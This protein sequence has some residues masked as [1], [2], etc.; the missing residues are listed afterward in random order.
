[1]HAVSSGAPGASVASVVLV[2]TL[3]FGALAATLASGTSPQLGLDLQGGA[4][5]VLQPRT[6]VPASVL[7]QAIEIIRNRVDGLGVAE[8]DI[9]RQGSSIIVQLPG[10]R[11]RD[12]A[13]EVVGQT[14]ELFFRPVRE[15][16]P[17]AAT[18]TDAAG[19][20]V[21]EGD[22]VLPQRDRDGRVVAHYRVGP[23][24]VTGRALSGAR[25]VV[26]PT[27]GG[28]GVEFSLTSGGTRDWN[29]M[30]ERIGQ[31]G[32]VAIDL[33]GEIKSAPTLQTTNFPGKGQI[34]GDFTQREAKDLALVLRYGS[35]PVQLEPQTVQTVS[36][37]LGRDS[38]RAGVISGL[39][40]LGMVAL[41][42]VAY[43]RALGLVVWLGLAVSAAIM[44]SLVSVLGA[45]T[46]LALTLAGATGVIVSVGVT[47]DSYVVFF[48]RL[49][50]QV[51]AGRSIR[52]SVARGFSGAYRTILAA[53]LASFLGAV[54][55]YVLTVGS[56]RGFAFFLALSTLLDLFIAFFFTR[57][58][59]L[60]LARSRTFTEARWLGVAR[61]LA[62]APPTASALAPASA[63]QG[64]AS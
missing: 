51:R 1:M 2:L 37:T 34:T 11:N 46:G 57:P 39:V 33:D 36:A 59:V 35:L 43:Y 7:D 3:A 29:D 45:T 54:V 10:V 4:S 47:V 56:V 23:S 63:D 62:A 22:L 64:A 17:P 9:S 40:G 42:M 6:K 5:V 41:Y 18:E 26:N 44:Y 32:R 52:S 58:L 28:W 61:G 55:L 24:E 25:A 16:L 13:L 53:D 27:T 20:T 14:A 31:G 12:R 15:A 30:A 49:K 19:P 50:D 48:E 8:P 21:P 38:L 60:L